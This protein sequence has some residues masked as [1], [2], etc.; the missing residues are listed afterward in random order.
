MIRRPPRSTLFPYTTL[1]R[2]VHDAERQPRRGERG[3][4]EAP[5]E[6]AVPLA[7]APR[8][9]MVRRRRGG[10]PGL[11]GESGE[12]EQLARRELLVRARP[13]EHTAEIQFRQYLGCR[14]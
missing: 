12:R 4:E 13:E 1:F 11:L 5:R 8:V 9:Q 7:L 14:L 2:S 3:A 10:E 6:A